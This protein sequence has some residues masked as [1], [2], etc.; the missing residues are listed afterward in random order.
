ME[1]G[2]S[3]LNSLTIIQATQGLA[4]YILQSEKEPKERGVVIGHD[5]RHNSEEFAKLTAAVFIEKGFKIYY[6]HELVHTPLVP[7]GVKHFKAIAGIM[8]TASHVR[9]SLMLSS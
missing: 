2:F 6:L 8:I 4:S 3:R 5:H 9:L 7:F 1:A